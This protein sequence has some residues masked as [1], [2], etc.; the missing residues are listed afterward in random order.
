MKSVVSNH[1]RD[2]EQAALGTYITGFI[3]SVVLT[4]AAYLLVVRHTFSTWILAGVIS[5]LAI[6]QFA[7]QLIFFLH[8]GNDMKPRFKTG[9]FWFMLLVVL[10]VVVG[11]LWIMHSLNYRMDLSPQRITQY[12][13]AQVG[14]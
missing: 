9:A 2:H 5:L 11:S 12:M 13:N 3:T 10:I 6:A 14:L 7:V 4:L 1:E 8:L